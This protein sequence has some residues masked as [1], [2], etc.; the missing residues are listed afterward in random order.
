[1]NESAGD[2]FRELNG[3]LH[4]FFMLTRPERSKGVCYNGGAFPY[5]C[6]ACSC[7]AWR[8]ADVAALTVANDDAIRRIF[9]DTED[10]RFQSAHPSDSEGLVEREVGL[11][12]THQVRSRVQDSAIEI[13]DV[14]NS[15]KCKVHVQTDAQETLGSAAT[16]TQSVDDSN[17]WADVEVPRV[18]ADRRVSQL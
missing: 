2:V 10:G 1:M 14:G 5:N 17:H 13:A 3:D 8:A 16:N 12:R 18:G 15:H 11:V 9:A 6:H 7:L 4:K